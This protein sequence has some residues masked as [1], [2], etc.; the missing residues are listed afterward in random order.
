MRPWPATG[1][2]HVEG[3]RRN[4]GIHA[5]VLL[6]PDAGEWLKGEQSQR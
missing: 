1:L 3:L 6:G 2:G 4:A 5:P